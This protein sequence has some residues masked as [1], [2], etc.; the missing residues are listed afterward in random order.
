LLA[1]T[2]QPPQVG[3][4]LLRMDNVAMTTAQAIRQM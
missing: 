1:P 2:S 3:W 4:R